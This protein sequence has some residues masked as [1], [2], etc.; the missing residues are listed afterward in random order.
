MKESF[1]V[2]L[3]EERGETV[4]Y[5]PLPCPK[6]E[7]RDQSA[8]KNCRGEIGRQSSCVFQCCSC[9]VSPRCRVNIYGRRKINTEK[10]ARCARPN[11]AARGVSS[12]KLPAN[13]NGLIT[14]FPFS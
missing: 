5:H 2:D 7:R 13:L 9:K 11:S 6:K 10:S 3:R 1:E 14:I 12:R 4:G 8:E